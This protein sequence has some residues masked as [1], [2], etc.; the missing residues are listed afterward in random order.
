MDLLIMN[1]QFL[2]E[3]LKIEK[4]VIR[5]TK[6]FGISVVCITGKKPDGKGYPGIDKN[7]K[8]YMK[9][10]T[11]EF[12]VLRYYAEEW[13][14][15]EEIYYSPLHIFFLE[16]FFESLYLLSKEESEYFYED[17]NRELRVKKQKAL[18][19]LKELTFSVNEK[20]IIGKLGLIE[21][22]EEVVPGFLLYFQND[23]YVEL[24]FNQIWVITKF[25]KKLN[26][27]EISLALFQTIALT[28]KKPKQSDDS[29]LEEKILSTI[30]R[31]MN[32]K[33]LES[34]YGDVYEVPKKGSSQKEIDEFKE[35]LI[36]EIK[37]HLKKKRKKKNDGKE[38]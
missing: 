19:S 37:T 22:N 18:D 5:I 13:S 25:I 9:V 34:R 36:Y 12:L 17:S 11:R 14:D 1:E 31:N 35:G 26:I 23:K 28:T 33:E 30:V 24:S 15:N 16:E 32:L 4:E 29:I 2:T 7:G 27:T 3:Y 38:K 20:K 8:G 21:R 6:N 10:S